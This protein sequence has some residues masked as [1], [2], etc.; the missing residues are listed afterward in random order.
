[1]LA[2]LE[3]SAKVA[4]DPTGKA[5][6]AGHVRICIEIVWRDDLPSLNWLT[7]FNDK[8]LLCYRVLSETLHFGESEGYRRL[9]SQAIHLND[10]L[11]PTIK[12]FRSAAAL[13]TASLA[14]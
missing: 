6:A 8:E 12:S 7:A 1:M 2:T 5:F 11:G 3:S 14:F 13:I 10:S 9:T 4:V